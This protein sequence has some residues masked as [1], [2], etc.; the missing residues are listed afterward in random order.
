MLH[1]MSRVSIPFS[2]VHRCLPLFSSARIRPPGQARPRLTW[3]G[4]SLRSRECGPHMVLS[5]DHGVNMYETGKSI[6]DRWGNF[7][8]AANEARRRESQD[9]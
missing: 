2:V 9:L 8:Q 3:V 7:F 6:G 5:L 1:F 4:P